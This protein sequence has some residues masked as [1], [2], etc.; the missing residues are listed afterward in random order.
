MVCLFPFQHRGTKAHTRTH[1]YCMHRLIATRFAATS[2]SPHSNHWPLSIHC[3]FPPPHTKPRYFAGDYFQRVFP[4][5]YQHTWPSLFIGANGTRSDMH[6]DS[7]GTNFWLYL[8]SGKKEWRFFSQDDTANLYQ[9]PGTS[10]FAVDAF[11]PDMDLHP[12][13]AR[14]RM[15]TTT[16]LP[17]DLVFIPGGCPHAVRNHDHIHGISMN[18]VDSSNYL[19]HLWVRI[20][21]Q[22]WR[23]FELFTNKDFRQGVSSTQ[24]HVTFGEF[25]SRDK[26]NFDIM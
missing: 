10:K 20:M 8:L 13:V 9:I 4:N 11:E 6:V 23:D 7:G 15:Y 2:S 5:G 22:D 1:T 19:L 12:L 3:F 26:F 14:A 17:G 25:K 24:R 18:Y 16:Q 21:D